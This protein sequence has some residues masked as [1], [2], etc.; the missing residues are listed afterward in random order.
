[1]DDL[2]RAYKHSQNLKPS[3][4]LTASNITFIKN[5]LKENRSKLIEEFSNTAEILQELDGFQILN[6]DQIF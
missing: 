2:N 5:T 6:D 3:P 4:Q 1:L